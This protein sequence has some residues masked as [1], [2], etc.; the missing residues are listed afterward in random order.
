LE[1]RAAMPLPQ[2]AGAV[3]WSEL[4]AGLG[5]P[6]VELWLGLLLGGFGIEQRGEFYQ[7]ETIWVE[8]MRE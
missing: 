3:N 2:G 7:R 1:G 6:W 5:M 8:R 4:E